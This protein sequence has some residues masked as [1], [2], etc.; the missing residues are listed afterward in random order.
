MKVQ[1]QGEE[2]EGTANVKALTRSQKGRGEIPHLQ[3]K[4]IGPND[5]LS[6]SN[7]LLS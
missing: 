4:G 7:F 2:A 3:N 5:P 1:S 6:L